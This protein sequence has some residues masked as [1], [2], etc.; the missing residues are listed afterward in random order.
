[1]KE[2]GVSLHN[3]AT[4]PNYFYDRRKF[5]VVFHVFRVFCKV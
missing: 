1:M 5:L 4:V 2:S 3:V